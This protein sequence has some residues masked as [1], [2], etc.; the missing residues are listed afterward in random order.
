MNAVTTIALPAEAVALALPDG[1][2][3][4]AWVELGRDLF[5]RHR[6]TEWMLADW[7]KVGTERFNDEEQFGLFL[8]ELGVD[9]K[10]ALADAKV[11]RLIPPT[12]RSDAVSFEV[13][14][15][16]AKIEDES[17]RQKMIKQ[18]V[19]ERWNTKTAHHAIVGHKVETGQLFDDEDAT[20]RFATEFFR[21]WN[22]MPIEA[23]EYAFPL[24]EISAAS[25]FGPIDEDA[26]V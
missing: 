3:F 6:Q 19:D 12:W 22:R 1:I 10:E 7:L 16:I 21:L 18:A 13:C 9:V 11:A 26:A 23:R 14:K 8:G 25:G 24:L 5:T 15:Q 4:P 20:S 17:V 2:D